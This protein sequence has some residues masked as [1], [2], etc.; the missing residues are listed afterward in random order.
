[1]YPIMSPH[2]YHS[3]WARARPGDRTRVLAIDTSIKHQLSFFTRSLPSFL[4]SSQDARLLSGPAFLH[5]RVLRF[6]GIKSTVPPPPSRNHSCTDLSS[7]DPPSTAAYRPSHCV[8]PTNPKKEQKMA[9][10]H[11]QPRPTKHF[12]RTA[13][14][15][16]LPH[17]Y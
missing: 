17:T 5:C 3:T 4:P 1:M 15:C 2:G 8:P 6:S 10:P 13:N 7:L 9:V 16:V 14:E 12:V 11:D